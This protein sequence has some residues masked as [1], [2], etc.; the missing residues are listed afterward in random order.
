MSSSFLVIKF[1]VR[2]VNAFYLFYSICFGG[3]MHDS[4]VRVSMHVHLDKKRGRPTMS[5]VA[6]LGF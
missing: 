2:E 4:T 6:F 5:S 3:C 1:K